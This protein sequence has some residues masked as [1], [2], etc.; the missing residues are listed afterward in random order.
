MAGDANDIR[1][2]QNV[3][4]N[5]QKDDCKELPCQDTRKIL[6]IMGALPVVLTPPCEFLLLFMYGILI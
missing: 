5:L 2:D 3:Q 1:V 4:K 6:A